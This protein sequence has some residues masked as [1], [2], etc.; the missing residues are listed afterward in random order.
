[1][2]RR[3]RSKLSFANVI[4]VIALF[5]V[6]VG[7]GAYAAQQ[8]QRQ[9]DLNN[10]NSDGREEA[11]QVPEGRSQPDRRICYSAV[12]GPDGLDQRGAGSVCKNLGL[13][14]PT[15]G[16]ALVLV[17]TSRRRRDLDRRGH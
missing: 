13:R 12:A 1:M 2:S 9:D 4:A 10:S 17:M 6:A 14:L 3:I 15:I 5:I 7:G 11:R 16:E 8:D